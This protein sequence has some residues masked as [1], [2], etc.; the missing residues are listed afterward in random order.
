MANR[1][2]FLGTSDL[3]AG[4]PRLT[5]DSTLNASTSGCPMVE[6]GR[7]ERGGVYDG[8]DSRLNSAHS[9]F[10]GEVAFA[11]AS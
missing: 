3:R 10:A 2:E 6:R 9:C 11:P 4:E 7:I 1:I 5:T 8:H